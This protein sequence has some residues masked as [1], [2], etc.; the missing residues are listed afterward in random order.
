MIKGMRGLLAQERN[1]E[2]HVVRRVM[3][4]V[5]TGPHFISFFQQPTALETG[6]MVATLEIGAFSACS[7]SPPCT[8]LTDLLQLRP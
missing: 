5:I 2:R 7:T 6:S 8:Q 1:A 3:S 4:G